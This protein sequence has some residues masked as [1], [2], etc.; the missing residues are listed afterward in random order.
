MGE[1]QVCLADCQDRL[2]RTLAA[3]SLLH[4]LQQSQTG[5]FGVG[6]LQ[7]SKAFEVAIQRVGS[8]AKG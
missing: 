7:R 4:D 1:A 5:L 6:P 8:Q 2:R 3:G